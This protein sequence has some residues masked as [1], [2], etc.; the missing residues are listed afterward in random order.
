MPAAGTAQ[1]TALSAVQQALSTSVLAC[2]TWS[3]RDGS[4]GGRMKARKATVYQR[5]G[6]I[7]VDR[8]DTTVDGIP[9]DTTTSPSLTWAW[10]G[11][12]ASGPGGRRSSPRR[13][14]PSPA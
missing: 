14:S 6:R 8:V 1:A 5:G 10:A 4:K 9:V 7:I 3:S 11:V 13:P 12:G 2:S